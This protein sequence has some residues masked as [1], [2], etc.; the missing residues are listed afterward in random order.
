MRNR[1][2][3]KPTF[4]LWEVLL[5][6]IASSIIMSLA[7]GYAVFSNKKI[8]D[9]TSSI[10]NKH[11][12]VFINSYNA[13]LT[14]Y[15]DEVDQES[16]IDAAINGMMIYLD[17]PYTSYLNESSKEYLLDSLKG[18]YEGIG[19]E[20]K[21]L[22]DESIAI[23]NVFENSPA[24]KAGLIVGDK[25]KTINDE[26]LTNKT[27]NDAVNIIKNS[28][29]S[30]IKVNA[31]R[32]GEILSFELIRETLYVPVVSSKTFENNGKKVGYLRISKFSD[33]VGEQFRDKLKIL[34]D[35]NI[36]SLIIDVRN[37]TGGYLKG[38]TEI[39]SLFLKKG[40]MIYS[41]Q[42]KLE[43]NH[44]K[45]ETDEARNYPVYIITNK[46]SASASEVLAAA[47]KYSYNATLIGEKTY[48]K[49]KVQQTSGL[50]DGSMIKYTTAKWLT[51]KGDCVDGIGLTPNI[52]VALSED[53]INNPSDNTDNQLQTAIHEISK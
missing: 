39:A 42:S 1:N 20:I 44:F 53:Y 31:E 16:L 24:A 34:E 17:D 23:M 8:A 26:P 15:Y 40:E 10:D 41:L 7:T 13:I 3:K 4:E 11:I 28:K 25:I 22:E 19:I 51:P 38:A 48:G 30:K 32:N 45:D 9:C 6:A 33:S 46:A 14:D 27:A 2:K 50:E 12:G 43:T 47:L 52:E 18:T 49:G 21:L 5:I 36:T 29:N 35:E 37:N